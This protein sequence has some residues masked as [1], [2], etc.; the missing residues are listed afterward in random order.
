[1]K[2]SDNE[3]RSSRL[4]KIGLAVAGITAGAFALKESGNLKYISKAIGDVSSTIG[5][6]SEDLSSKAFKELDYT[7]LKGIAKDSNAAWKA[8]RANTDI[9]MDYSRGLLSSVLQYNKLKGSETYLQKEMFDAAQKT[10]VMNSLTR[11]FE[12]T[13]HSSGEFFSELTKLVDES[14]NNKSQ[15][16]EQ[17]ND[18]ISAI[19]AEFESRLN[20]SILEPHKDSIVDVMQ[21]AINDSTRREDEFRVEYNEKVKD[22]ITNTFKEELIDKYSRKDDFFKSTLDRAATVQDLLDH[23]EDGRIKIANNQL[24]EGTHD[25]LLD[26]LHGLV[27]EDNRFGNLVIDNATLRVNKNGELYSTKGFN[28][29]KYNLKEEAADTIMGIL[30]SVRSF[31]ANQEAPDFFYFG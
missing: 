21:Q 15:F 5:K 29:F 12:N 14:L 1:M 7:T 4:E 31:V 13:E 28:D 20:G 17:S 2:Y 26:T 9:E 25:N 10:D 19:N 8:S 30:F 11:T 24:F 6:V 27:N 23:A 22:K 18:G 3:E 16:F